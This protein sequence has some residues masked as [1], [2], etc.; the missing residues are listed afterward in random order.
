VTLFYRFKENLRTL[1]HA[2]QLQRQRATNIYRGFDNLYFTAS[3][4]IINVQ[5][6]TELD[7]EKTNATAKLI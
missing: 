1:P 6:A 5:Y 2:L 4:S 7:K 3:G